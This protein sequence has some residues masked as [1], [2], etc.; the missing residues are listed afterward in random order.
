MI[1]V[2]LIFYRFAYRLI[3]TD[4]PQHADNLAFLLLLLICVVYLF[5]VGKKVWQCIHNPVRFSFYFTLVFGLLLS[6][7]FIRLGSD[8]YKLVMSQTH[9]QTT[10]ISDMTQKIDLK[11]D[12]RPDIYVIILDGYARQ[13]VLESMYGY[14]NSEFTHQLDELGFYVADQSHSNYVQTAY[15][16]ASLWNFE[17]VKPWNAIYDYNQYLMKPIQNNR[18]Y[19]LLK[20][21]GYTTVSFESEVDYTEIKNS[22][23]YLSDFLSLNKFESLLLVDSPLE[24][25]N[26]TFKLGFPI[27]SYSTHIQRT[28]YDLQALKEIS[29]SI[30]GPKI[31]YAH[32]V[33]PHPPFVLDQNGNPIQKQALYSLW[34]D[35]T[36]TG[37][38]DEYRNGYV[39]QVIF[40]NQEILSVVSDILAKSTTPPIILIMGDHGP[41]SQFTW[42]LDDCGCVWE[43][44]SNLYALLLPGHQS[45]ETL[46]PTMTPVNTF[47]V[48]FDTYFGASLPLLDDRTYMMTWQQPTVNIDVTG[49]RDSQ[50]SCIAD[51]Q[52]FKSVHAIHETHVFK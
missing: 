8:L 30:P 29:T 14:D 32:I 2:M 48:I 38:L 11:G 40:I 25:F 15:S 5:I 34:D 16:M 43:R 17:Y 52:S 20:E 49:K 23:I 33:T 37:G 31:V 44:T 51:I 6:F 21:L 42:H 24:P 45:D 27:P 4:L 13:D 28:R 19:R 9:T 12:T 26:N 1:W 10:A 36:Y 46:Y 18:T 41:A 47:R 7:Q 22:D 50:A 39:D 3:K 35:T